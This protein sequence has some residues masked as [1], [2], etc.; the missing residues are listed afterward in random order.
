M[1]ALCLLYLCYF[2]PKYVLK[3]AGGA[4]QTDGVISATT[5]KSLLTRQKVYLC[6]LTE[7]L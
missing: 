3:Q 4:L 2:R 7:K 6:D 1:S 5:S